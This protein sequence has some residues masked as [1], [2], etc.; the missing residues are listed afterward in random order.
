MSKTGIPTNGASIDLRPRRVSFAD[1]DLV[2]IPVQDQNAV[3]GNRDAHVPLARISG[4]LF[5]EVQSKA[6]LL[7]QGGVDEL[8][9]GHVTRVQDST[10]SY[11]L[12]AIPS[13][14]PANWERT[15]SSRTMTT[16]E[17]DAI[18]ENYGSLDE[19][20]QVYD[21]DLKLRFI[22]SET[23]NPPVPGPPQ[24]WTEMGGDGSGGGAGGDPPSD[25]T[26]LI[27]GL[28]I[29]DDV[30]QLYPPWVTVLSGTIVTTG[31][32]RR[33]RIGGTAAIDTFAAPTLPAGAD[34]ESAVEII[35][36]VL[37]GG[38]LATGGNI[39][40]DAIGGIFD[41]TLRHVIR[42]EWDDSIAKWLEVSRSEH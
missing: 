11:R 9:L 2:L 1:E 18:S 40:F 33:F 16:P 36:Q 12:L 25:R 15:T 35:V 21:I 42:L 22:Y 38:Q 4:I 32:T 5:S 26:S 7:S 31:L 14:D 29:A 10:F 6:D 23:T 37:P 3:A 41:P 8:R 39:E 28:M 27:A 34:P 13:S 17:F 24:G 20:M 19:G 30:N